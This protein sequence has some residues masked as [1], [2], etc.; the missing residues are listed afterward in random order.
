MHV[1]SPDAGERH[2]QHTKTR[3]LAKFRKLRHHRCMHTHMPTVSKRKTDAIT[4][5]GILAF[6]G[7]EG[8][9]SL[10]RI[11]SIIRIIKGR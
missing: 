11:A 1:P 2:M 8:S 4:G 7:I 3:M 9:V 6:N 5:A 10:S